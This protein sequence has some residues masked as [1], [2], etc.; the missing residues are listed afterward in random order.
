[1]TGAMGSWLVDPVALD[2][3]PV[4]RDPL[5]FPGYGEQL[6][7]AEQRTGSTDSVVPVRARVAG[8][9]VVAAVLDFAFLGGSMGEASGRRLELAIETALRDRITFVSVVRTGGARMQEGMCSLVQMQRVAAALVRL[10]SSG[11]AHL[12]VA[13]HPTT[14]G[15]WASLAS[16]ADVVVAVD[17]ATV[18]F[19]GARVRGVAADT[20]E[21]QAIGKLDAGA[22]DVVCDADELP[23]TV[24]RYVRVL[25]T[26]LT[27]A[28]LPCEPPTA[29]GRAD[30]SRS[31]WSAVRRARAAERPRADDYLRRYFAEAVT[32]S[33]DRCGGRDRGMRC[34]IGVRHGQA[35]AFVAQTGTANS[36][37][38]FR[39]ASRVLGLADYL[40]IPVLTLVDTP[41]AAHD[42]RAEREGIGTAIAQTF[43]AMAAVEVPVTSLLVGEGGSGGALA[44]AAPDGLWAVPSSY[45]SVIA[46]EGAAAIL[47]RDR[48]RAPEV[49]DALRITPDE[50]VE[51]GV[52]KG[53][54]D[55][56][57]VSVAP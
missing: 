13:M 3:L 20:D 12:C 56:A 27:T 55:G 24:E 18:A 39:T 48:R 54:V 22:V 35:V 41:G 21:F 23:A 29:M 37:A 49:A 26:C 11:V 15:I 4:S 45:F 38:G 42:A 51:L 19:A 7:R 5:G 36:A 50:L 32:L 10:R 28:P 14:G 53:I 25:D 47:H 16:V 57:A 31:G 43:A 40:T 52:V 46:P 34:G 6:A 44:I 30:R 1:M 17:G 2:G 9:P 8:R 33:G